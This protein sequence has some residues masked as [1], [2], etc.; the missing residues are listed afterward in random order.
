MTI[1]QLVNSKKSPKMVGMFR[2]V[3]MENR[4]GEQAELTLIEWHK[5]SW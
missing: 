4:M 1:C 5:L 2:G 3:V